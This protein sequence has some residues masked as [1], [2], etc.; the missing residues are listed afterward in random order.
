MKVWNDCSGLVK[1]VQFNEA[2]TSASSIVSLS[3]AGSRKPS[4]EYSSEP[5]QDSCPSPLWP[6]F[7]GSPMGLIAITEVRC[8]NMMNHDDFKKPIEPNPAIGREK[9]RKQ[10]SA[11]DLSES[12]P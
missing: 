4:C 11:Y 1:E 5:G 10:A 12:K 9:S 3:S 8:H 6:E 7:A 2:W